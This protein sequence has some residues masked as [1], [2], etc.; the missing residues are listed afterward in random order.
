MKWEKLSIMGCQNSDTFNFELIVE[1][2]P[3]IVDVGTSTYEKNIK[4]S[5]ASSIREKLI[6]EIYNINDN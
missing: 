4:R 3:I 5:F 6:S 1:G 2:K